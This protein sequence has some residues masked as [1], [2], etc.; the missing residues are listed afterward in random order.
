[1]VDQQ[2]Q[3]LFFSGRKY[4]VKFSLQQSVF[5]KWLIDVAERGQKN[6]EIFF[7]IICIRNIEISDR[8]N[9]VSVLENIFFALLFKFSGE[10]LL[11]L[12]STILLTGDLFFNV[13]IFMKNV[14]FKI[15]S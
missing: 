6:A 13:K 2:L 1:M 8:R 3:Q 12:I 10:G 4:F 14:V 5:Q 9:D 7:G 11:I 15:K